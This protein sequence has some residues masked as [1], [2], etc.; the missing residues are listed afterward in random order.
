[1]IIVYKKQFFLLALMSSV[2]VQADNELVIHGASSQKMGICVG[3]IGSHNKE[4]QT[5]ADYIAHDM[6]ASDQ[7][8]AKTISFD[9]APRT[10]D[11]IT[12]LLKEGYQFG[13]FIN[14]APHAD[15]IEYRTYDTT[16][17]HMVKE[18]GGRY[19]KQK[20]S[21]AG[22]AHHIAQKIWPVLT[23]NQGMFTSK[24]AYSKEV[25]T[26][27]GVPIKYICV[28]D[29][30]GLDEQIL[31]GIPTVNV[32]PRW[33]KDRANP[34]VFYSEQ[35]STRTRL[36]CTDFRRRRR[37]IVGARDETTA[38]HL[39]I[40]PDGASAAYCASRG[41]GS[42]Q[43]YLCK[44]GK[45]KNITKNSGNNVSLSFSADGAE[46]YFCSDFKTGQ[47]QI[48]AYHIE[49]ERLRRITNGGY[50]ASPSCHPFE[51]KLVYPKMMDT[52]MQLFLYDDRTKEHRQ[53][54]FD[55]GSKDECSWSPC[56]NYIVYECRDGL[57]SII[58]VMNLIT[59]T[60]KPITSPNA[61]CSCPSW[62]PCFSV[63]PTFV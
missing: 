30:D 48:F 5:M 54:T 7:F 31:V 21:V 34:C 18:A 36:I 50:C 24:I 61:S 47:P 25:A 57:R 40:A 9:T 3:C 11:V 12:T 15:A 4:L 32:L 43:I 14:H 55:K 22:W 20:T 17:G 23:G 38:M 8:F 46:I 42:C 19:V 63:V 39:V 37:P 60:H 28:A 53:I 10:K 56:G 16:T 45:R 51:H 6:G 27:N 58:E 1:M 62:S 26:K 59:G 29:Y 33:S 13:I 52:T 49:T 35:G 44:G 41:D 2:S